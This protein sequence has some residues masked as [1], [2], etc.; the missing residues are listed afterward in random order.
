MIKSHYLYLKSGKKRMYQNFTKDTD[1][2]IDILREREILTM[3]HHV[4]VL[5]H[6]SSI[7]SF[8]PV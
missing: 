7:V 1:R 4:A 6:F 8:I 3:Q 5:R 2:V